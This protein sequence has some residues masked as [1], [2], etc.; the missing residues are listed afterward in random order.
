[1]SACCLSKFSPRS[2]RQFCSSD[3]SKAIFSRMASLPALIL[4][5]SVLFFL[6]NNVH[7]DTRVCAPVGWCFGW[8]SPYFPRQISALP[9]GQCFQ[10]CSV[11]S[12]D[13]YLLGYLTVFAKFF[14]RLT[15]HNTIQSKSWGLTS[16]AAFKGTIGFSVCCKLWCVLNALRWI[17]LYIHGNCHSSL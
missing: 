14:C 12:L 11:F 9:H 17:R 15:C 16:E 6:A 7:V 2:A 10:H 4:I 3:L 1:M 5:F 8:C 13:V